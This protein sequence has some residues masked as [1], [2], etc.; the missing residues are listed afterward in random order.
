MIKDAYN[1]PKEDTYNLIL[2][3][4]CIETNEVDV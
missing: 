3:D 1:C 4:N 2:R